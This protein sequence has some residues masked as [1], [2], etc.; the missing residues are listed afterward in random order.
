[1]ELG[2]VGKMH[3]FLDALLHVYPD[4][5]RVRAY[6]LAYK[7]KT[8]GA[9]DQDLIRLGKDAMV[10]YHEVMSPW[11]ERCSQRD[12]TLLSED[13][14]FLRE[15]HLPQKW[16]DM[17]E[18][19]KDAVWQFI[20]QL[21]YY[22]GGPYPEPDGELPNLDFMNAI[23]AELRKGIEDVAVKYTSMINSG[24]MVLADLNVNDISAQLQQHIGDATMDDMSMSEIM[25]GL[26]QI[27]GNNLAQLMRGLRADGPSDIAQ[28]VETMLGA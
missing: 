4:C 14:K 27:S 3:E 24:D 16:G 1:M 8:S 17:S 22:C 28:V 20:T 25:K 6:Q 13:I 23:P 10:D 21:N 2:F 11:Y 9:S 5:V 26:R 18:D 7:T 12:T 15:L 19:T